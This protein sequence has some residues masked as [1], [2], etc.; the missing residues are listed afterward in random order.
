MEKHLWQPLCGCLSRTHVKRHPQNEWLFASEL[1]P[2]KPPPKLNFPLFGWFGLVV[3]RLVYL[4][5]L[6]SKGAWAQ[7]QIQ[8]L[9]QPI[10][11]WMPKW[12]HTNKVRH[13]MVP[14]PSQHC[15]LTTTNWKLQ[16]R[17]EPN[18]TGPNKRT[19]PDRPHLPPTARL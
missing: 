8:Q 14:L 2:L 4:P 9:K 17:P 13:I 16:K 15:V 3:W 7:V 11:T 12:K 10:E 1:F 19:A 5:H 18:T 6:A